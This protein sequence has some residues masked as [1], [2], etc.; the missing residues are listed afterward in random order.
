MRP[1][2]QADL[3][4]P[5]FGDPGLLLDFKFQ[6]RALLFDLGDLSLLP[7]RKLLRI[8]DV[9]VTHAHMD[10]FIGFD[11][12]LRVRLGRDTGLRLWGPPGFIAQ[13]GHR[14]ASYTWNL[15]DGYPLEFVLEVAETD[16]ED[17]LRRARFSS[18]SR[19]ACEDLGSARIER[20]VL[21][22][23]PDFR[24]RCAAFDHGIP[25]LG[26]RFEEGVHVNIWK[27]RLEALGLPT[28]PWLSR[29]RTLVKQGAADDTPVNVHWRDRDGGHERVFALGELRKSVLTLTPGQV[30]CYVSDIAGTA[31]N[32]RRLVEFAGSADVLFIEAVF[33]QQDADHA[34]RKRHLTAMQAGEFARA[35]SAALAVPFHFSTRYLGQ[36]Q[37]LRREFSAAFGSGAVASAAT[38]R[39]PP[40]DQ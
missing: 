24:L 28:G 19:F 29:L 26:F 10:H 15:L 17:T 2:F 5:P 25:S 23:E 3:V 18:R 37:L 30:V 16:G 33:L 12:L 9:F 34:E 27:T 31:A 22:D 11:R 13:V 4:N 35:A 21:L 36:E 14:L 6:R 20:G 38:L 8:S 39:T 7:V 40:V 1:I 32:R